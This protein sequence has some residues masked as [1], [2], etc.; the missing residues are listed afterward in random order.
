[1]LHTVFVVL[2]LVCFGLSA[3]TKGNFIA[4]GLFCWLAAS[5]V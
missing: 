3:F 5:L 1:M 2:A 4:A